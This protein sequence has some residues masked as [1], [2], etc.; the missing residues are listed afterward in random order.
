MKPIQPVQTKT[1][2]AALLRQQ[3]FSGE[4]EAGEHLQQE[5]LAKELGVSRTPVR[6]AL[7]LLENEGLLTRLPNRHMRVVGFTS[8]DIDGIFRILSTFETEMAAMILER[9]YDWSP[10]KGALKRFRIAL[11]DSKASCAQAE[12][13]F[14]QQL[15]ALTKSDWI[16][17]LHRFLF[18]GYVT[19]ALNHPLLERQKNFERLQAILSLMGKRDSAQLR[20]V[21]DAYF[22]GIIIILAKGNCNE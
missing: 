4:I 16:I 7:Q 22:S 8:E 18:G 6:E 2:I 10:L 12:I 20:R 14:H 3:I 19:Y 1:Y 17:R 21:F 11:A 9:G 13:A 5:F 15:A